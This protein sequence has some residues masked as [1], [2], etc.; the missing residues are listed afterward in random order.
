MK[1]R[2]RRQKRGADLCNGFTLVEMCV[3]IVIVGLFVVGAI[4]AY[5]QYRVRTYL[6]TNAERQATI[7]KAIKDFVIEHNYIPCVAN[8]GLPPSD[9]NYGRE[10]NCTNPVPSANTVRTPG[11]RALVPPGFVRI[12]AVPVRTLNLPDTYIAEP[13]DRLYIYA[14]TESLTVDPSPSALNVKKGAI[15]VVDGTNISLLTPA[16]SAIYVLIS[17][18]KNGLGAWTRSGVRSSACA[19]PSKDVLNCDGNATFVS[20]PYSTATE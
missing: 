8:P 20:A 12:G 16:G 1:Y 9:P 14:V 4:A 3:V 19:G 18:G 6:D 17:P 5:K 13:N 2:E 10:I 15:D 11:A 7:R